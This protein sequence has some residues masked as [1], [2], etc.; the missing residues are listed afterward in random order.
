MIAALER[1]RPSLILFSNRFWSN[2]IDKLSIFN[3]NAPVARHVMASYRPYRLVGSHWFW[4]RAKSPYRFDDGPAGS[5]DPVPSEVSRKRDV[6]ATGSLNAAPS[7]PDTVAVFVTLGEKNV[8]I[9]AGRTVKREGRTFRFHADVP[10]AALD[11]GTALLKFWLMTDTAGPLQL[12]GAVC[13][14]VL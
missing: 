7:A 12:L 14:A 1:E 3:S 4:Q 13:V 8:P 2:S 11:P 6:V 10:T 5:L 9:W